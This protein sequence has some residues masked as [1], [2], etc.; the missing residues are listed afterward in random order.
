MASEV[1]LV[2]LAWHEALNAG[3][4]KQLLALSS[5]DVEVGG[6]RGIG[7][8]RHLLRDWFG[9]AGITLVPKRLFERDAIVVVEQAATWA[10]GGDEQTV[11]SLFEV[12]DGTVSRVVRYED[13]PAALSAAEI[14]S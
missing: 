4:L 14:A 12:S 10:A 13:V 8:G 1:V 5:E 3:D 7:R 9:R 2:V 11:A 6:P